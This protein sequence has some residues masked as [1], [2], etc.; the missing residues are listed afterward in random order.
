MEIE[1]TLVLKKER[2]KIYKCTPPITKGVN[3]TFNWGRERNHYLKCI[4]DKYR[5]SLSDKI[6]F[7]AIS[8]AHSHDER[9]VF[10]AIKTQDGYTNL[11]GVHMAGIMTFMIYGGDS[12][13]MQEDEY[14]LNEL[15]EANGYEGFVLTNK[16]GG[17]VE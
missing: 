2:L 5:D 6:E 14:Y 17:E 7:V 3:E 11:V 9:L 16:K 13:T 4:K 15:S 10:P 12:S 8:D 1:F